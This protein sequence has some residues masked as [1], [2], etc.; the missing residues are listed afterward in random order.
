MGEL[1]V[2]IL[3]A[4]LPAYWGFTNASLTYIAPLAIASAFYVVVI[5]GR[6]APS[7]DGGMLMSMLW[8][9]VFSV[10]VCTIGYVIGYGIARW[11]N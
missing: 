6:R 11:A 9:L 5:S 3:A 7:P 2:L 4:A 10:S 8:C 1:A